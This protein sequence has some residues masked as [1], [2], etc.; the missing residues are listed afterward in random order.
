LPLGPGP[1]GFFE[2][3]P[4]PCQDFVTDLYDK[5]KEGKVSGAKAMDFSYKS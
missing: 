2:K 3:K 5:R 1:S 4:S